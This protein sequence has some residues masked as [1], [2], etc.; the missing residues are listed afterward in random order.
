L[1]HAWADENTRR[2]WLGDVGVVVRTARAPK[3]MRLQWPDD[4]LVVVG[5][6]AKGAA[7]SGVALAHT[8]LRERAACGEART[9]WAERLDKLAAS[10]VPTDAAGHS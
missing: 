9:A 8:K 1:F 6:T 3:S 4:T 10:L 5:F 2:R 7:R